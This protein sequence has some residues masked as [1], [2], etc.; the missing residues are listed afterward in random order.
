MTKPRKKLSQTLGPLTSWQ[1]HSHGLLAQTAQTNIRIWVYNA[2]TVRVSISPYS[3]FHDHSYAVVAQPAAQGFEVQENA[4]S[5]VLQTPMLKVHLFKDQLRIRLE[6]AQGQLLN[7][8][9]PTLGNALYN[10]HLTTYKELQPQERFIGL[11]EKTG[12]LDRKGA[13][14]THWNTDYFAYPVEADPLYCSTPFY[15]GLHNQNAYG[16]FLNNPA[17]SHFNFGASNNRFSSVSVEEGDLDYFLF[18]APTVGQII[19][20]YAG[21]TGTMPL[22]PRWG[23]GYQQCRYSYYPDKEVLSMARTFREKNIPADVMYLDIHYMDGY[24]VFSWDPER[25]AEPKQMIDELKEMGFH[26]AVILDPGIK[27]Q[28]DYKPYHDGLDKD[29]YIKYND[30][31]PWTAEVWP[32]WCHFPDFTKETTRQWWGGWLTDY[33]EAGLEGFWNDMNE[34]A[35]WGQQTPENLVFDCEGDPQSTRDAKNLYGMQMSRATYNGT[36]KL[37]GKRPL[38]LT[39]AGFSGVQRYSAVWTGDNVASDEHMLLGVRL[40]NSLGLAG[41]PFAGYD[42]GGFSGEATQALFARW[43]SIGAFSPFFRGHSMVNSRDAEPWAFGEEVEEISRNYINLRYALLPYLYSCFYEASQT[44]MPV[45]RSL[46]IDHAFDANIYKAAY[47]EE[48]LFGPSI[49]V[50]PVESTKE[51]AKVYL[52][53]GH[54]WYNLHGGTRYEG[55][56]EIIA[57][58]PPEKLP[59]Y[60]AEGAIL[61]MQSSVQYATQ[62]H[63]GVLHLHLYYGQQDTTFAYYEDDGQSYDYEQGAYYQRTLQYVAQAQ[64]L[65]LQEAEGQFASTFSQVQLYLHGFNMAGKQSIAVNGQAVAIQAQRFR[66]MDPITKF[67]PLGPEERDVIENVFMAKFEWLN[68]KIIVQL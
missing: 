57:E 49:L 26:T 24:K 47:Q 51:L 1:R 11:G 25:F 55:G 15:I 4:Q 22:P 9:H 34:V 66:Y 38:I 42:V 68:A 39:R 36:K 62:A 8:D 3:T 45:V 50:A 12:N 17:K 63:D 23:L 56:Q 13:G 43:I 32:G 67:D 61:P 33:V 46:A 10:N 20:A 40:V 41:V 27:T 19:Q 60:V 21:L 14:F 35:S 7:Q 30:G 6:N 2:T 58:C 52:P 37:M 5:V 18:H 31:E 16:L 53:G 28:Q 44:G 54:A 48:Y 65:V 64:Q 59:L 29:V